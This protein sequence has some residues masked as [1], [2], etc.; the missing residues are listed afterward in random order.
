MYFGYFKRKFV[1]KNFK[2]A[3]SGHAESQSNELIFGRKPS[4]EQ[5]QVLF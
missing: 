5:F 2:I 3:Q 1:A 4:D